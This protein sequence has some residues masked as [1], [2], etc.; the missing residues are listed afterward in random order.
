L[1]RRGPG[2]SAGAHAPGPAHKGREHLPRPAREG[3]L[4]RLYLHD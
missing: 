1:R 4:D 3:G 2:G